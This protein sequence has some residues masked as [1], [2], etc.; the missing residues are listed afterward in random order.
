MS[1]IASSRR[2]TVLA[3]VSVNPQGKSLGLRPGDILLRVDGQ[4]VDGTI[5][6]I[7]ALFRAQPER[8]RALWIW[9]DGQ[10]WPVMGRS[11]MLGRWRAVP[12][13]EGLAALPEHRPAQRLR[14]YEL[15]IGPDD[16]YDAQP[17]SPTLIA[18]VPPLYMIQMRLWTPLALWAALTV[19]SVPLGWIA[20]AAL[21][22]LICVYFWRAAPLLVRAD[23]LA[24]G[25]RMWRVIAARS[26]Q[27][28]H[29]QMATLA[30]DLRFVHA[31]V[32]PIAQE[33]EAR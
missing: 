21:H 27:A 2:A 32:R 5:K 22:L 18:L 13:P 16:S 26:E 23:R 7:Q 1:P 29:Q 28:L 31:P 11:A 12:V 19:V 8:E 25:F 20:G 24:R 10:A 3:L 4:S 6:D 30:P 17:R 33:A 9:R 15:M 14:N